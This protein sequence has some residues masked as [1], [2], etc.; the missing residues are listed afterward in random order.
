MTA[1]FDVLVIGEDAP[2][3][4][5]AAIAAAGGASVGVARPARRLPPASPSTACAPNALWRRLRLDEYGLDLEP[6]SARITLFKDKAARSLETTDETVA[7][8]EAA[9]DPC[10]E[11]WPAFADDMR[12]LAGETEE[13]VGALALPT[14]A[15]LGVLQAAA[16]LAGPAVD[17]VDD[18]LNGGDLSAHVSAH[19]L[20][21]GGWGGREAMSAVTL[22]GLF[23]ENSWRARPAKGAPSLAAVLR[24]AADAEG[25]QRIDRVA[26]DASAEGA[27]SN[28]VSLKSGDAI[29][30]RHIFFASPAAAIAAGVKLDA[31]AA[32]FNSARA[33]L[34]LRLRSGVEAPAGDKRALFQIV[35]G[36][37]D[38][39][40]AREA[41]L[42]G[43]ITEQ[44][45][46]RFEFSENGDI[47]AETTY[48]PAR[49]NDGETWR[50]WTGQDRQLIEKIM[51]D[52]LADRLPGLREAL[53]KA[54]LH[55]ALAPPV[56][57]GRFAGARNLWVQ[58]RRHDEIAAAAALMDKVL[59]HG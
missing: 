31:G 18:Y 22:S 1:G 30:A 4:C 7:A 3:Y 38:L 29:S 57:E 46:V 45:P 23:C 48:A 17:L 35:D 59:A 41:A 5:A 55:L 56:G 34:R 2:G 24:K 43:E 8:L 54:D 25:A 28:I 12:V 44:M 27:K 42:S 53:V 47:L 6:V 21:P 33:S 19:G 11:I 51:I 40:T 20:A 13:G 32:P 50:A 39:A 37:D 14:A 36:A 52:R 16:R 26:L 15:P 58:T 10:A 9:N 49:L